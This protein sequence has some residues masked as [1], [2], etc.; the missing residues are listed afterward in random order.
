MVR[1]ELLLDL[2]HPIEHLEEHTLSSFPAEASDWRAFH[3]P[4]QPPLTMKKLRLGFSV[5]L[6]KAIDPEHLVEH[7]DPGAQDRARVTTGASGTQP[8]PP[9]I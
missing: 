1:S 8:L 5:R 6:R 9:P 3:R 4:A 7:D 2:S